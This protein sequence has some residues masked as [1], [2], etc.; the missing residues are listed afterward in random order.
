MAEELLKLIKSSLHSAGEK[1]EDEERPQAEKDEI[2]Y[3]SLHIS[4]KQLPELAGMDVDD[5]VIL[6]VKGNI[7]YHSKDE[8]SMGVRENW[9]VKVKKIGILGM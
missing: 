7:S 1:V 9:E 8:D 3:P 6:V 5:S 2:H 4:Y